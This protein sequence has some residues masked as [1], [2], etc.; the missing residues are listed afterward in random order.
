MPLGNEPAKILQAKLTYQGRKFSF[1]VNRIRLPNGVEGEWEYI[2]HPGGALVVPITND[3]KLVLV[4]QYRFPVQGRIL[5]FP[6]GTLEV[7][8]TPASTVEREIQE[9]T[10]YRASEWQSL[11]EFFL[12]PGYADEIIYAFL[13]R[14]LE[15]L[16]IQP[17]GDEDE[18]IETVLM[19]PSEFTAAIYDGKPIDAKSIAAYFLA[20]RFLT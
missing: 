1:N 11:G 7:G 8:E 14:D 3:G 17:A 5:E 9:E 10:G 15:K 19:T 2:K 16:E 12:A 6:A 18:D 20:L 4:E 13:A